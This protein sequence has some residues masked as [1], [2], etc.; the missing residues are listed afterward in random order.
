MDYDAPSAYHLKKEAKGKER[1]SKLAGFSAINTKPYKPIGDFNIVL[2]TSHIKNKSDVSS[3]KNVEPDSLNLLMGANKAKKKFQN[4]S[5]HEPRVRFSNK[6]YSRSLKP[7]LQ[8]RKSDVNSLK[9]GSTANGGIFSFVRAPR[10]LE[11]AN[12]K[13][14]H[15]FH[16]ATQK[17]G[18]SNKTHHHRI[19]IHGKTEAEG[20]D[21]EEGI[22]G[23]NNDQDYNRE[24]DDDDEVRLKTRN[25]IWAEAHLAS[26]QNDAI[27]I[28][29][30]RRLKKG[31]MKVD[32]EFRNDILQARMKKKYGSKQSQKGAR[33]SAWRTKRMHKQINDEHNKRSSKENATAAAAAAAG[34]NDSDSGSTATLM[35]SSGKL[36]KNTKQ[37]VPAIKIPKKIMV[38]KFPMPSSSTSPKSK[39][40]SLKPDNWSCVKCGSSNLPSRITCFTCG[41]LPQ[42]PHSINPAPPS[43]QSPNVTSTGLTSRRSRRRSSV[44]RLE[45]AHVIFKEELPTGVKDDSSDDEVIDFSGY[46]STNDNNVE[47]LSSSKTHSSAFPSSSKIP[48]YVTNKQSS[49]RVGGG[50]A[51]LNVAYAQSQDPFF[52]EHYIR[53][54]AGAVRKSSP[55]KDVTRGRIKG[56]DHADSAS[57]SGERL[58][59]KQI[60]YT[61]I[62]KRV[63]KSTILRRKFKNNLRSI[64]EWQNKLFENYQRDLEVKDI[65][66]VDV[67]RQGTMVARADQ[68][69]DRIIRE[70]YT[71]DKAMSS[72]R[73]AAN[74]I[75]RAKTKINRSRVAWYDEVDSEK[76]LS[77]PHHMMKELLLEMC[78]HGHSLN[79]EIFYHC[80]ITVYRYC[81]TRACNADGPFQILVK[82]MRLHLNIT[83]EEYVDWLGLYKMPVP[84]VLLAELQQQELNRRELE[85]ENRKM[86]LMLDRD[87]QANTKLFSSPGQSESLRPVGLP[88]D[89]LTVK[90]LRARKL[91]P[92]DLDGYADPLVFCWL[93]PMWSPEGFIPEHTQREHTDHCSKTLDPVWEET[94]ETFEF[95]VSDE[96]W[97]LS[98]AV[99]DH[100]EHGDNDIMA[101]CRVGLN[102]IRSHNCKTERWFTL[103]FPPENLG[104]YEGLGS[105]GKAHFGEIKLKLEW[106]NRK[107]KEWDL[108]HPTP[109]IA[110]DEENTDSSDEESDNDF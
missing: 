73:D 97:G 109:S 17:Y 69:L 74:E 100:D 95:E 99:Y 107:T 12:H 38:N 34:D 66:R 76:P 20:G 78:H 52:W 11:L 3:G 82:K 67:L 1:Y 14:R 64:G 40:K 87:H 39:N 35:K 94:S 47:T 62:A 31:F 16:V 7:R 63:Q 90:V 103:K 86:Q 22:V 8:Q 108:A 92:A 44:S 25:E 96:F 32:Q 98:I 102:V 6:Q 71:A 106:F 104:V 57:K 110:S 13:A 91:L 59:G 54:M 28:T 4:Y 93:A 51:G 19:H 75:E 5:A 61:D 85:E 18:G 27:K 56:K 58:V 37:T 10:A 89:V 23:D 88:P 9:V 45:L 53:E 80:V 60:N 49:K 72:I 30:P 101:Y 43:N 79:E 24:E 50:G 26:V 84:S 2:N 15:A 21:T 77:R 42:K 55:K 33:N 81:G 68:F 70:T 48:S 36:K 41:A 65:K 29:V 83:T 46:S 105:H